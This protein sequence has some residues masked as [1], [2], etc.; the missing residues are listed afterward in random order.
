MRKTRDAGPMNDYR[1]WVECPRCGKSTETY[2]TGDVSACPAD[3]EWN[4]LAGKTRDEL[5]PCPFCGGKGKIS[6]KRSGNR[7]REGT[8]YY[9]LCNKCKA[10]GPMVK[11]P[12]GEYDASTGTYTGGMPHER[13]EAVRLWN[14]VA[15]L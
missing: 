9:A 3:E 14:A 10:R 13:A 2:L 6:G 11:G 12:D 4:T 8:L 15:R 1:K 5:L 7:R